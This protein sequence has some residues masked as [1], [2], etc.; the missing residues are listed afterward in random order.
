MR[1]NS[2]AIEAAAVGEVFRTN[3]FEPCA[4]RGE[5]GIRRI[6]VS[7]VCLYEK[8]NVLGKAGCE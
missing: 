8:V 7:R 2:K 6:R 1:I 3:A 4:E 5:R